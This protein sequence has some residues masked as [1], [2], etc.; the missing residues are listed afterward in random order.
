MLRRTGAG[1]PAPSAI[2][3]GA[4]WPVLYVA[5][6]ALA[7]A[8]ADPDAL[9]SLLDSLIFAAVII[10]MIGTTS[11]AIG[12]QYRAVWWSTGLGAVWVGAT[13]ACPLSGH[14]DVVAA[15][16]W[17]ELAL[18]SVLLGASLVAAARLR[19]AWR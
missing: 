15:Q 13:L 7:P 12:R 16:W 4:G 9:P 18:G 3:L 11:A 14:H 10:G 2:V 5:M 19:T 17:T 8:P 1:L 6:A